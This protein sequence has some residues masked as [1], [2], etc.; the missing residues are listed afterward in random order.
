MELRAATKI[1]Q[2]EEITTQYVKPSNTT[3]SRQDSLLKKWHFR[4]RYVGD[5]HDVGWVTTTTTTTRT[6]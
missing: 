4:C 3:R 5:H 1:C 6:C 2:G